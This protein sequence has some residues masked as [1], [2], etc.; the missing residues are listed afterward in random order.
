[1][2]R[3]RQE[4]EVAQQA[5]REAGEI[6][7]SSY[8]ELTSADITEKRTN[9]MVTVVDVK[10]QELIVSALRAVFTDDFIVG[11]ENL[12]PDVNKGIAEDATRRWYID[13]LDGTTNYIHA[14][15]MF[16]VSIALEVDG[17]VD[18]GVTFDPMR[19]E[20]FYAV[21]GGGAFL[22]EDPIH[23]SRITDKRRTLL[24]TGFPF[25]ARGYLDDYLK[26]FRYF[27]NHSRGIRRAG[28]ATLDLA[29][30]AA[31]RVDAFWETTL[32][33]W[34]MAAGVVLVEEAGGRITD[35]FQG[36]D[37]L[38]NGHIV[39]TNGAFHEWMCEA[40][41]KVFPKGTVFESYDET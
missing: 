1:M 16:A 17:R 29:Y 33:P 19:D 40:I 25:R 31:G 2:K 12:G 15:P 4:L 8:A 7:R 10:S 34:D 35:F 24:A 5:A 39:A 38:K 30:V 14:Y 20:M 11:E 23:V 27:F 9:D 21:R 26:T 6:I 28:S 41:Q 22:N 37:S 3:Y 36:H 13:P 32:S 18:A